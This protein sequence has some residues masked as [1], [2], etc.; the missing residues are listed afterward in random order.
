MELTN[1][2]KVIPSKKINQK[3]IIWNV[4]YELIEIMAYIFT[5]QTFSNIQYYN[6]MKDV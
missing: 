2:V 1:K 5:I 4:Q 3:D 6:E